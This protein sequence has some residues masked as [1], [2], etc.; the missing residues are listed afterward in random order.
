MRS[1]TLTL[2]RRRAALRVR[3]SAVFLGLDKLLKDVK[4]KAFANVHPNEEEFAELT[5]ETTATA[6]FDEEF[7]SVGNAVAAQSQAHLRPAPPP[8]T[9]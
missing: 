1:G 9:A 4:S 5:K 7:G 8:T 3:S 2:P 6:A